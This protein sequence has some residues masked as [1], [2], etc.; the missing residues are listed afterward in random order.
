[1][2]TT[3]RLGLTIRTHMIS[4]E[5][6]FELMIETVDDR[7]LLMIGYSARAQV[8]INGGVCSFEGYN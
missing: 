5:L 7:L 4:V 8:L 2:L 3:T 6:N 1:M